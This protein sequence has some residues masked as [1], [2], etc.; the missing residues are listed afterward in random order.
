MLKDGLQPM[1][2]PSIIV[3]SLLIYGIK[4]ITLILY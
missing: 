2:C 1:Q 3:N 4:A